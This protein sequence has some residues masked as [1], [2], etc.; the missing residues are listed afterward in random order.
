MVKWCIFGGERFI[1]IQ[2]N[3]I[4]NKI[5]CQIRIKEIKVYTMENLM[6]MVQLYC[7]VII[8]PNLY[9]FIL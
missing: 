2:V 6:K 1:L 8:A 9:V 3:K 7:I 5:N 4:L